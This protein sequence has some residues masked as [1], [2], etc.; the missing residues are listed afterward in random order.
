MPFVSADGDDESGVE[1]QPISDTGSPSDAAPDQS[2]GT[3]EGGCG[4]TDSSASL[5]A[6]LALA[7]GMI[8]RRRTA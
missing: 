3:S 2:A 4:M 7:A 1:V 6:A 8:R 5:F